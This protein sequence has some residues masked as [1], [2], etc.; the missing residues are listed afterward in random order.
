MKVRLNSKVQELDKAVWSFRYFGIVFDVEKD[1]SRDD[2]YKL[3]KTNDNYEKLVPEHRDMLKENTLYIKKN[4]FRKVHVFDKKDDKTNMLE[5]T[6][7]LK[8]Q[9]GGNH[10]SRMAIQ[11]IEFI[12]ANKME[13]A[14]ANIVKYISRHKFKNGKEDILKVIH[15]CEMIIER[16]YTNG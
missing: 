8:K 11:P 15:Y 3:T 6:S 1:D 16:D 2:T 9:V 5:E 10:Y 7:V 12:Q 14:E 4:L 13:Y